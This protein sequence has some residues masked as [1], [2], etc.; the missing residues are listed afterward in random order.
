[1][2]DLL[3]DCHV[4]T[5]RYS[6]CSIL[7]PA[8]AC[9]LA[10]QRGLRGLV[11]TEHQIQWPEGELDRLRDLFPDLLLFSGLEISLEEGFDIVVLASEQELTFPAFPLRITF[12]ELL[13]SLRP[14]T[15]ETFLFMAHPFR[16]TDRITPA[17]ERILAR[18]HG[19]EMNSI[20]ILQGRAWKAGVRY[21]P[22]NAHLY[23]EARERF[24]LV[25][26]FNSDSHS[27]RTIG[28]VANR[29][30]TGRLPRTGSELA[31]LL[32]SVH[33]MEHQNEQLLDARF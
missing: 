16:W 33:P 9:L 28:A 5:A 17:M 2:A 12:E 25:P 29:V 7:D 32:K 20:N 24:D 13:E 1:M 31:S 8:Q 21:I 23:E 3:I 18:I 26:L 30:V 6:G 11:F 10:R 19:I 15:G 14:A 27:E 4:H 22:R